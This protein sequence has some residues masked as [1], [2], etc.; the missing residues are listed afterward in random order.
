MKKKGPASGDWH[1]RSKMKK[2]GFVGMNKLYRP[3]VKKE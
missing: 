3:N 1:A 2:L